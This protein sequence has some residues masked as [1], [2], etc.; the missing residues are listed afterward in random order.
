MKM[1]RA[2]VLISLVLAL[3]LCAVF[4]LVT[5]AHAITKTTVVSLVVRIGKAEPAGVTSQVVV[6]TCNVSS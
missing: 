4:T 5:D 2:V 1:L 3:A 6:V